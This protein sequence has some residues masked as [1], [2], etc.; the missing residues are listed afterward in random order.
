MTLRRKKA[1]KRGKGLK[2][3]SRLPAVNA[4]RRAK[5]HAIQYGGSAYVEHLHA[6]PCAVCAVTGWTV[7]AHTETGGMGMKAPANTLVPLCGDRLGVVGCHTLYDCAPWKLPDGADMRLRALAKRL[8]Q[9]WNESQQ[10]GE[11]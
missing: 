8:W 9:E 5:R 4:K 1:L 7:A 10:R 3:K 6:M 2:R 11:E